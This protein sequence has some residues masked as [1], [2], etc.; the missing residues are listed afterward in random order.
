[1]CVDYDDDDDD[2]DDNGDDV[3]TVADGVDYK[4]SSANCDVDKSSRA[5][6]LNSKNCVVSFA[7]LK[8]RIRL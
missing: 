8:V 1:M 2:D 5:A 7:R 4:Q 3:V 6:K